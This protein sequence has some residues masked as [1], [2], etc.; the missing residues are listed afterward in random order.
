MMVK[1]NAMRQFNKDRPTTVNVGWSFCLEDLLI[2]GIN[3]ED[4]ECDPDSLEPEINLEVRFI[5]GEPQTLDYPGSGPE[6]ELQNDDTVK[7]ELKGALNKIR[8]K[9]IEALDVHLLGI[10]KQALEQLEKDMVESI[11]ES[12]D[13]K[14]TDA[15]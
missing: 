7:K 6:Y 11:P 2:Y 13:R 1:D 15:F 9:F 3:F 4:V 14:L 10:Q 5:P 8:A 12:V